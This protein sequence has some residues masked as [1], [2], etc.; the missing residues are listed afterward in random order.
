MCPPR[1]S[2]LQ[3]PDLQTVLTRV[4]RSFLTDPTDDQNYRLPVR[5]SKLLKNKTY[6]AFKISLAM[7]NDYPIEQHAKTC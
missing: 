5:G 2:K 1:A 4:A 3:P 7:L 6:R